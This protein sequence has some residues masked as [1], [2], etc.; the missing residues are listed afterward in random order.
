MKTVGLLLGGVTR[1]VIINTI[2]FETP[3][4]VPAMNWQLRSVTRRAV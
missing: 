1:E 3:S 4:T 2:A